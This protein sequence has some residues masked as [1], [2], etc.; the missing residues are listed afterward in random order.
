MKT[1]V[2]DGVHMRFLISGG[3]EGLVQSSSRGGRAK[4]RGARAE[5]CY[6]WGICRGFSLQQLKKLEVLP[7]KLGGGLG[8][9]PQGST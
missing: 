2:F 1:P 6:T 3:W 5:A 9:V 7:V 4:S 8:Q